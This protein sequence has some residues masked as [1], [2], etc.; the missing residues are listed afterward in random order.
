MTSLIESLT[1]QLKRDEGV[2]ST[3]YKD[4]LGYLTIGVGRL[5]DE[6]RI[7]AG[8]RKDEIDYLLANDINDRIEQL[9]K[10]LGQWFTNLDQVRQGALLNMAFQ[11]GV[12][13]VL[14]FKNTLSLIE[15]GN[16]E[17]AAQQM[18]LSKWAQ[19]TPNRANRVAE[20]IK[21]GVWQ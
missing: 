7:G 3:A 11:L 4:S 18:L 15:Q 16:Y 6:R 12:D 13:G 5:I 14:S 17:G 10:K 19:Q 20:Q 8:L 1:Q 9:Q 21:T 2:R